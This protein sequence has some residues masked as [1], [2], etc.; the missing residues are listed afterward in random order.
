MEDLQELLGVENCEILIGQSYDGYLNCL[1]QGS[2]GVDS[3]PFCGFQSVLDNLYLGLPVVCLR[4]SRAHG[5]ISA[6]LMESLGLQ[7]IIAENFDQY[8][9][10]ILRLV[11]DKKYLKKLQRKV[12]R[13]SIETKL[14]ERQD[15]SAL[16]KAIQ[17][18]IQ[19]NEELKSEG[20]RK[21]IVIE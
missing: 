19:N 13:I 7:E 1:N 9:E 11:T 2:F 3:F 16:T 18:L 17:Y 12:R 6:A 20:S 8:M 14:L 4:G 21:P 5:R 10:I 15:T